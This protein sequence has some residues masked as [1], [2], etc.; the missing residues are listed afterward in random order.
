MEE[1][2]FLGTHCQKLTRLNLKFC[3]TLN[4][5]G[6]DLLEKHLPEMLPD[7]NIERD[8]KRYDAEEGGGD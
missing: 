3:T 7:C 6:P 2:L 8:K 4:F 1:M 5:K